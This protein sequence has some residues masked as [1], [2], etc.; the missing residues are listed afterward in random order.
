[1]SRLSY[2]RFATYGVI[3]AAL[4]LHHPKRLIPVSL[5]APIDEVAIEAREAR[6]HEDRMVLASAGFTSTKRSGSE[7]LA[8]A[9]TTAQKNGKKCDGYRKP[10]ITVDTV[11]G[12]L[13]WRLHY[14]SVGGPFQFEVTVDDATGEALFTDTTAPM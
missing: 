14:S 4:L 12:R 8:I 9:N 5:A 3:L 1:M 13:R 2:I 7:V 6:L 11:A 10:E